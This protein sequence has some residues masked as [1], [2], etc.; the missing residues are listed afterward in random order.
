M[1]VGSARTD[2]DQQR[3]A[4]RRRRFVRRVLI[5]FLAVAAAI[6]AMTSGLMM[7]YSAPLG[8]PTWDASAGVHVMDRAAPAATATLPA[9]TAAA[10]AAPE[11]P[12]VVRIGKGGASCALG[13]SSP[14]PSVV[15]GGAYGGGASAA[16]VALT[17]DDGPTPTTSPP[18]YSFLEQSHTPATFFDEGQYIHLWPYLVQ[19]EWSDGFAIGLHSW[20]HPVM[21]QL[22]LAQMYH[23]FGDTI[24]AYHSALGY[25]TCPWFW[26]PPYGDYN[27]TVV[28]TARAYGLSTIMWDVDPQDWARPGVQTIVSRVL[29]QVHP[30]AIVLM[31]DGPALRE[32]TAAALPQ[33][34][35]GLKVRGLV[36]VTLPRLLADNR[37]PGVRPVLQ[38]LTP[39]PSRHAPGPVEAAFP[40]RLRQP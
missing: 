19:R 10:T 2:A 11:V 18:I 35:A 22:S 30:G 34:V 29:A 31:H 14:L 21:S 3:I 23:Q 33:I 37:Y 20:D 24:A 13:P 9:P 7:A 25:A 39:T 16:E 8:W 17:F 4:N 26:R 27:A 12:S 6:M 1:T 28:Q 32:Q 36:P 38:P 15:Y 40:T 5:P